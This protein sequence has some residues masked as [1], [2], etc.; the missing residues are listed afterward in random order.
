[1]RRL[2]RNAFLVALAGALSDVGS[3]RGYRFCSYGDAMFCER[4]ADV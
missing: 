2:P 1:M 4:A 3:V